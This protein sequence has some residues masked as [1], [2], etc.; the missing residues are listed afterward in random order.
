MKKLNQRE[1]ILNY[2]KKRN[3][4]T[5]LVA[6]SEFGC[7]RLAAR[8]KEL[9]ERGHEI[10]TIKRRDERG[11]RYA[12][13]VLVKEAKHVESDIQSSRTMPGMRLER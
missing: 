3:Q 12:V 10:K 4:L 2:L 8:I 9:R 1:K 7:W 5:Q 6:W 11:T 13:Y